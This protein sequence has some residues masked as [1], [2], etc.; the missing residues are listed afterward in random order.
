MTAAAA[1]LL[2]SAVTAA[3]QDTTL[4]IAR[5]EVQ[6]FI[7]EMGREH[8]FDAQELV[9]VLRDAAPQQRIIDTMKRPAEATTPWWRYRQQ[10]LTAERING[11]VRIWNEHRE[12]LERIAA[13]TGVAPQYLVAITGVETFYGRNTGSYRVLDALATLAFDYPPRADYFRREL[14]QMLLLAREEKVDPRSLKGS[15][16]GA[17]GIAQ[18]MPS[19][20]RSYAA[21]GNGDGR[22]DLW[23]WNPDVFASIANYLR[24]HG[25]RRD[26]PVLSDA[27]HEAPP[28]DPASAEAALKY[29]VGG[30]RERGYR[31]QTTL[32]DAAQ[33]ML[34]PAQ[35]ESA[36]TWRVG[37][38]NFYT[39]TRY[40]RSLLYAMAVNDLADAIAAQYRATAATPVPIA[41]PVARVE[42]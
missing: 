2:L 26:E 32:P 21:D 5:P 20:F 42:P 23:S 17:M 25:W 15:Y 22:R 33:A 34:V 31:F 3:A 6:A 24:E 30:L 8:S 14:K 9:W 27:A 19:S 13:D 4:D 11:G 16:A 29:T 39:I 40:N 7:A 12:A 38:Q 1:A 35:Q 37:Y 36:T 28:D 10:F 18:F 41:A